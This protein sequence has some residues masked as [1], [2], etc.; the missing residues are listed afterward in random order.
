MPSNTPATEFRHVS[1]RA[2]AFIIA[3][4]AAHDGRYDYRHVLDE[5]TNANSPVTI[6]CPDHG[7]FKQSPNEHRR[8]Q[9]CP[10]C[11]RLVRGA[12][13]IRRSNALHDGKYEYG[14]VVF[15]DQRTTVT[16]VC[17]DHGAFQQRPTNHLAG[18][19]CPNC[20]EMS[21]SVSLRAASASRK[22]HRRGEGGRFVT[23][24]A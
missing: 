21:R 23:R 8:A 10:D 20:A 13:F 1:A 16:I 24:P 9:P 15:V 5:Y 7:T 4:T 22:R 6:D 3:A 17:A 14:T 2:D 12:N 11:A 18:R 19:G